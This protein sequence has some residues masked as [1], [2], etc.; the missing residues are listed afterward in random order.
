M[1]QT[2]CNCGDP[3]SFYEQRGPGGPD[4][5]CDDCGG[6]G[7]I[8]ERL[9]KAARDEWRPTF[10]RPG[11]DL[12]KYAEALAYALNECDSLEVERDEFEAETVRLRRMNELGITEQDIYETMPD[13]PRE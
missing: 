6:T 8:P 13:E 11:W 1:S 3:G 4:P 10:Q 9:G 12:A 7:R 2:I 5:D